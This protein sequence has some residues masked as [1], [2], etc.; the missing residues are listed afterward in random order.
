MAQRVVDHLEAVEVEQQHG[1]APAALELEIE[2]APTA[3]PVASRNAHRLGRSVSGS[4]RAWYASWASTADRANACPRMPAALRNVLM[5]PVS[6][7]HSRLDR[8][9]AEEPDELALVGQRHGE[10]GLDA[11]AVEPGLLG[12]PGRAQGSEG[13]EVDLLV[14]VEGP[15]E[16][17]VRGRD[18]TESL[19]QR[20]DARRRPTRGC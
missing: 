7:V 15:D 20:L 16:R 13:R 5:W 10:G 17:D 6:K 18:A 3:R 14:P 2:L 11:A 9:E 1:D 8:L 12:L 4:W 19:A